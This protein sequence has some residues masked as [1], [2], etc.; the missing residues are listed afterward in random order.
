MHTFG[1]R[2]GIKTFTKHFKD[3]SVTVFR[4]KLIKNV[5][6]TKTYGLHESQRKTLYPRFAYAV[7]LKRLENILRTFLLKCFE[8]NLF[9]TFPKPNRMV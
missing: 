5:S 3:V 2:S 1:L 8:P 9:K 7:T 4:P 6:K